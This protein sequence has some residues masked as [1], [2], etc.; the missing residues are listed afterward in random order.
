MGQQAG[1]NS[2]TLRS[3]DRAAIVWQEVQKLGESMTESRGRRGP[4]PYR[5]SEL[6][7]RMRPNGVER[8]A[9]E[10]S[11]QIPTEEGVAA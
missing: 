10:I 4:D 3:P 9:V 1:R 6:D 7:V 8:M 11:R 5:Q 2:G